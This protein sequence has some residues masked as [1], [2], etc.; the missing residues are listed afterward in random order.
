MHLI[1]SRRTCRL[2]LRPRRATVLLSILAA[3]A[4]AAGAAVGESPG[5]NGGL[6]E[7]VVTA[8][9]RTERLQDVPVSAT[10]FS[11]QKL[12]SQGI[13]SIDDLTRLTPGVTFQR[14]GTSSSGNFNDEDSSINIRGVDSTAGTSTVGIY[15]DDTP[16][17]GRHI[18]FT[19]FNA[20]PELF[21]LERVEVLRG[22]Q[23]TL[24]GAG[25]EG[26]T[27]RFITPA[28]AL[29]SYSAYV[30]SEYATTRHG[31]P[32]YELG[33]AVGGPIVDGTVG[34][35]LSA[36]VREDGGWVDRVDYRTG[37][38]TDKGANW[39]QTIVVRG[40]LKWAPSDSLS[41][42][43]SL[44]YQELKLNDT[45]AYWPELSNPGSDHLANGNAQRNPSV[46]PFYLAAIRVDWN[47]AAAKLTSNTSYFSRSQ[48]SISDYTQFDRTL[49]GLTDVG[50]RPPAGDLGTSHDSDNQNN[51]YQEV[52]LQ[53]LD[54]AAW[55]TWTAGLFYSHLNENTTEQVYDPNLND[56]F[57]AFYGVPLCTPQAPCPG[58]N[59]LSQ[60]VSRIVDRQ[61]AAFGDATM[62][63]SETW[64]ATLGLRVSRV[65]YTGDLQYFGP[66]LSPS[67]GPTTPLLSTG[68]NTENPVT[69][70]VVISYQPDRQ[71]LFYASASKGYRV[72]GLNGA[73]SSLCGPNLAS[74]GLA[75]PP[76][77]YAS[78]SLWSYELGAKNTFLGGKMQINSS[79][80]TID[81]RR[82]QQAV[83]LPDCGQNFVENL[84]SV[85]SY[86]GDV[87]LQWRV[88]EALQVG[89]SVAY[90]DAKYTHT[91]CAGTA[92]CTGAAAAAAPVV[93]EGNRLPGAPWTVLTSFEYAFST[94]AA[95]HPYVRV[96]YQLTT[97]QTAKQPIQDSNNGVSDTS[98]VGLPDT[99]TLSARA[100]L[101]WNGIDLS[102]FGQNLT[103]SHPL[104]NQNR[105]NGSSD[106][107]Y[108][109]TVRPRTVG[110]TATYKY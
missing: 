22:P 96:D 49:F 74:I 32:S 38:V 37:T 99:K 77:T 102:V 89:L 82:I 35:R 100:G 54:P 81:W 60:P 107:F 103:D 68:G 83:Y 61:Y 12:D 31:D 10:A 33:A 62:R 71:S 13:R 43:P 93:T 44:Y 72:G 97:A 9:R 104:L 53:S 26:G 80:F 3:Q 108:A 28:P 59:I 110:L 50:P 57:N 23:G 90:G 46:D 16:I 39:K 30:R 47:L 40:A 29:D 41:I 91:V 85:R 84:G 6:D 2:P 51:F 65:S 11:Q 76:Q 75:N 88:T 95:K 45:S 19:S 1:N 98:Y 58:G 55:L 87:D 63:M 78:D 18:T 105:D 17:Q 106:L 21:D 36:Y 86:G 109:H 34:F 48:H 42:T 52:R 24:F 20:F 4:V 92:A 64:K 56:E 94:G 27:V 69:P 70:K 101:R 5:S 14:N 7:I 67:N 8:T 66:F 73:V 15:V 25:S 79:L